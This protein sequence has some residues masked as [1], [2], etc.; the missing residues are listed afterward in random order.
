MIIKCK[1]CA[2]QIQQRSDKFYCVRCRSFKFQFET[3]KFQS[4]LKKQEIKQSYRP[5]LFV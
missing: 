5:Y 1:K 2:S 3:Y 4:L